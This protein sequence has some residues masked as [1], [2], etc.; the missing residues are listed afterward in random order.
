MC[1]NWQTRRTQN[2]LLAR[3]CGFKSHHRHQFLRHVYVNITSQFLIIIMNWLV[4]CFI[5]IFHIS[6]FIKAFT[7]IFLIVFLDMFNFLQ[8]R[9]DL[10]IILFVEKNELKFIGNN[11]SG[12]FKTYQNEKFLFT[13]I[14][15]M[16]DFLILPLTLIK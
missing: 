3:A 7:N 8:R 5:K 10:I 9:K 6:N 12:D 11:F 2:P 4:I 1:R 15:V 14:I 13:L 16:K